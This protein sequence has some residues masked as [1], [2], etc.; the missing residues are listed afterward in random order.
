MNY[1]KQSIILC[2]VNLVFFTFANFLNLER[3]WFN[4]DYLLCFVL[5]AF[6][7][8]KVA[9]LSLLLLCLI[10]IL[11]LVRQVFPFFRLDDVFYVL[12]FIF[13]SSGYYQG[14]FLCGLIFI[15]IVVIFYNKYILEKRFLTYSGLCLAL[16]FLAESIYMQQVNQ[17]KRLIDSQV[18]EFTSLQ[19]FGFKQALTLDQKDLIPVSYSKA[20][21]QLYNDIQHQAIN[22]QGVLFI[23]AESL[24]MPRDKRVLNAILKPLSEQRNSFSYFEIEKESRYVPTVEGELRELCHARPQNFNL[25]NLTQGFNDCLPFHFKEMGYETT[26]MHGALSIMYDRK[27]WY[28]RAGF[29]DTIFYEHQKWQHQC[30]SFSGACD[31]ELSK[32]AAETFKKPKKQFFYWLTLNSHAV[33]DERDIF[34]D[35]FDCKNF[36]IDIESESCRNLKLQAQF[37]DV[38]SRLI[39]QEQFK[40]VEVVIVGDHT[41]VIFRQ[42]E[43][44]KYFDENNIL[45]LR[46]KIKD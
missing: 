40:G 11:L 21:Q 32:V 15:A 43:K 19:F 34:V 46:F 33:Y 44:E 20:N 22:N 38:L 4:I 2:L 31:V 26:A 30:Y 23:V 18:I 13:I 24:G 3:V 45:I 28:P 16:L 37:F 12:K 10:D 29:D 8:K 1:V 27:Y 39:Q 17:S 25:K 41:P 5:F 7:H 9:S 36:N 6:N 35:V 14:L 42:N